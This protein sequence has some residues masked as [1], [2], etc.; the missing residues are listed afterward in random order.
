MK[1]RS[2]SQ[3]R[4]VLLAP[5]GDSKSGAKSP[6][7]SDIGAKSRSGTPRALPPLEDLQINFQKIE[8]YEERALLSILKELDDPAL[9]NI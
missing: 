4:L 3:S 8:D 9:D 7:G 2:A 6:V 1:E 5:L